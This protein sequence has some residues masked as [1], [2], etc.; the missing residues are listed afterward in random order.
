MFLDH[1]F[2]KSNCSRFYC[3]KRG[4]LVKT[5]H[6]GESLQEIVERQA[7]A[8]KKFETRIAELEGQVVE[9]KVTIAHLQK[10]SSKSPLIR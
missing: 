8:I 6:G 1:F 5:R 4:N 7:E 3:T 9:L 10:D 2:K